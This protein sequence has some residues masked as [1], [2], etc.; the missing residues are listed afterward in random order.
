MNISRGFRGPNISELASNGVHEG[1]IRYELGNTNLSPEYSWQADAG[2]DF[3]SK[4]VSASLSL[5]ANH[6]ENYIFTHRLS[7]IITDGRNTYQYT[8]GNAR[9]WGGEVSIEIHPLERLHF[10]NTFSYVDSRQL[11]QPE[12]SRY[13]PFIPAPRWTS[14]LKF[15]IP[16]ANLPFNNAYASIGLECYLKQSHYYKH[17]DTETETPSY[18]LVNLSLGTDISYHKKKIATLHIIA[19]NI[20]DRAYQNHLSRL[21]YADVNPITGRQGVFDMGR[22]ICMKLLIPIAL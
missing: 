9:L 17:D 6:I 18:S 2:L 11:H 15:D 4:M 19:N 13:L 12:E 5:F 3:T 16:T 14:G 22:N 20:F 7:G 10:L 1:S 21:K 8:S